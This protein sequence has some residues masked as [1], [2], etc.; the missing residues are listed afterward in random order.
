MK[1]ICEAS[2]KGAFPD[3]M[4]KFTCPLAQLPCRVPDR[5]D[6]FGQDMALLQPPLG[7]GVPVSV[8]ASVEDGLQPHLLQTERPGLPG[9]QAPGH[10][11][12]SRA[13]SGPL[14]AHVRPRRHR[15]AAPDYRQEM[16][17]PFQTWQASTGP[18]LAA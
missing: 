4:V 10:A 5:Y 6:V 12:P 18:S 2:I 3:G 15:G 14:A 8:E 11:Q 9:G 17:P 1:Y 16:T 7:V 13:A